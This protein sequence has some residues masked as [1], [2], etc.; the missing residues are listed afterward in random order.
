M[1]TLVLI[2]II[3]SSIFS[4]SQ[5][6]RTPEEVKYFNKEVIRLLNIERKKLKL[7]TL[8]ESDKLDKTSTEWSSECITKNFYKH[9]NIEKTRIADAECINY[10]FGKST[11]DENIIYTIESFKG[12]DEHWSILMDP[13]IKYIGLGEF[14][15]KTINKYRGTIGPTY[16]LS[17]VIT[18][19]LKY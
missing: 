12:S 3:F 9:S 19:Q 18:I 8:I 16:H 7:D 6:L 13:D 11:V 2:L 15:N 5:N 4:F 14:Y 17:S 1:K 10:A